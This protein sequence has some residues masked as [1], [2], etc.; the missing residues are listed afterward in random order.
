MTLTRPA[1]IDKELYDRFKKKVGQ[2]LGLKEGA[3]REALE[4]AIRNW[5]KKRT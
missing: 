2:R 1:P 4:E 5:T 3:V